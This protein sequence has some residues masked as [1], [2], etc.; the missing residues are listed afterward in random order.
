MRIKKIIFIIIL[1]TVSFIAIYHQTDCFGNQPNQERKTVKEEWVSLPK[2]VFGGHV[3]LEEAM[4]QRRSHRSFSSESLSIEQISQLLWA[5]QGLTDTRDMLR[6]A[7]SAGALYPLDLYLVAGK[8]K[9]IPEGI[10]LYHPHKH[11]LK[12]ILSGDFR[13]ALHLAALGQSSVKQAPASLLFVSVWSRVTKKY[14]ERGRQYAFLEAGHAGQNIMLQCVV[15][16]LA[17]V[18]I[19]AFYDDQIRALVKLPSGEDPVYL[20]PVGKK[21]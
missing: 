1:L 21:K 18:P 13:D 10:Y 11:A 20:F 4:S 6:T 19:G 7:P 3:S 15:L 8:I 2:P 5:A 9:G 14:G 17:S 12:K 16:G